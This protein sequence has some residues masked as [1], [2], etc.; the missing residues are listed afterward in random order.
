[1]PARGHQYM[2]SCIGYRLVHI[3]RRL[4][5]V[6]TDRTDFKK[7]GRNLLHHLCSTGCPSIRSRSPSLHAAAVAAPEQIAEQYSPPE[8]SH[9][10][11]LERHQ[12]VDEYN[13]LV[14]LYRH[15]KT[16]QS[17]CLIPGKS[18]AV[19]DSDMSQYSDQT[20]RSQSLPV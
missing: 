10:F 1:M 20:S 17:P 16:G 13:S 9:G 14:A 4:R 15:E 3:Q 12:F 8:K 19:L 7:E 18:H 5:K 6:V 2:S 11:K